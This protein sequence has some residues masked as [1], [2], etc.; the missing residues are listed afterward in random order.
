[1]GHTNTCPWGE[2]W[3]PTI[4]PSKKFSLKKLDGRKEKGKEASSDQNGARNREFIC[5][6]WMPKGSYL[7]DLSLSRCIWRNSEMLQRP[8]HK[9]SPLRVCAR[10]AQSATPPRN[11]ASASLRYKKGQES[12]RFLPFPVNYFLGF[13]I[14]RV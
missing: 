1:M 11:H 13:A 6:N 4:R 2:R 12:C 8:C 3:S 7:L 9:P 10:C 5:W 14:D